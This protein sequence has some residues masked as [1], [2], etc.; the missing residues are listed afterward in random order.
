MNIKRQDVI[1]NYIPSIEYKS[2]AERPKDSSLY[3]R[4]ISQTFNLKPSNCLLGIKNS[5]KILNNSEFGLIR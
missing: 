2:A 4:L 1:I 3:S 5:L